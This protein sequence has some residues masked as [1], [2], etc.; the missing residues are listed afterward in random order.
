MDINYNDLQYD[1]PI[2]CTL[3]I[4]TID[5]EKGTSFTSEIIIKIF[6]NAF[7]MGVDNFIGM[8][9]GNTLMKVNNGKEFGINSLLGK[10]LMTNSGCTT[11]KPKSYRNNKF[12]ILNHNK[13]MVA[14]DIYNNNGTNAATIFDDNPI[15]YIDALIKLP[16]KYKY[17]VGLMPYKVNENEW[18]YDSTFMITLGSQKFVQPV[19]MI[20]YVVSGNEEIDK[21]NN[22]IQPRVGREYPTVTITNCSV[23]EY[24]L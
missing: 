18:Y 19:V 9:L 1:K 10:S 3:S 12:H 17:L 22:S 11:M 21:I 23:N 4:E 8:I 24:L 2:F 16:K 6:R 20:G 5:T 13:F 15:P 14:G 7:P